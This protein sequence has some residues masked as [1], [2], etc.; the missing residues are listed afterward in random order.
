MLDTKTIAVPLPS[1]AGGQ[2][3]MH[4]RIERVG[5]EIAK[6]CS[7]KNKAYGSSFEKTAP[8]LLLLFPDGIRT[9]QY[10]DLGLAFRIFDKLMRIANRKEAFGESP[11]A[12]IA[13]YGMLGAAKDEV[14]R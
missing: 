10:A 4:Q 8:F 5:T 9:D 7:E 11:F 12:D 6:L 1:P 14:P 2:E 3:T 13:G